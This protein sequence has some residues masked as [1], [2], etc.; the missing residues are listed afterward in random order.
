MKK[1]LL[2]TMLAALLVLPLGGV[3]MAQTPEAA[4][5]ELPAQEMLFVHGEVPAQTAAPDS[6]TPAIH[7]IVLAMLHQE[8]TEFQ[9]SDPVVGWEALYNMLSLYGE[10][11][12]RANIAEESLLLPAETVMDFSSALTSDLS[13]LGELPEELS[14]RIVYDAENSGFLLTCGSDSLARVDVTSVQSEG[15]RLILDGA[16]VYLVDGSDLA[17]FRAILAPCDNLFGYTIVTLELV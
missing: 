8:Q 1:T 11:D 16:L 10:M 7:G 5:L 6:I 2:T 15:D 12:D 3:A 9:I 4:P 14:D 13:D 17:A